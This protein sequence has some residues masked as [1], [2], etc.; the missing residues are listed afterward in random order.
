MHILCFID[1]LGGGGAQ[2]QLVSLATTMA[3]QGHQVEMLTYHPHDFFLS[4]LEQHGIPYKTIPPTPVAKR[5]FLLLNEFKKF[6][7]DAVL[8]FLERPS[9]YAEL[10]G[11]PSRRWGLV[12]SE[13]SVV[14]TTASRFSFRMLHCFADYVTCNSHNAAECL[15][16]CYPRLACKAH[17]IYNSVDL[18][19]FAPGKDRR[20][21]ASRPFR[22]VCVANYSENKNVTGVVQTLIQCGK[23][24]LFFEFDWYGANSER[25]VCALAKAMIRDAN[26]EGVIRLHGQ[27]NDV[28]AKYQQAD[29]LILGSFVEGLPNVVCEAMACGLPILMSDVA[30]ARYLVEPG[31]NGYLFSPHN[32]D[33]ISQ[34]IMTFTA[35]DGEKRVAMG[36]ASRQKAETLFNQQAN[37]N[38]YLELLEA[39]KKRHLHA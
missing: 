20:H 5:L 15:V 1:T 8:A 28:M 23:R 19:Q 26:M 36:Q 14:N 7:G 38:M 17:C 9:F 32:L 4:C 27:T 29:A 24:G 3:G 34:N 35:L 11:L 31:I 18:E 13:R 12:V 39:S 25:A 37:T 21:D 10:F 6:K 30:D 16:K 22:F 33:D 2:R